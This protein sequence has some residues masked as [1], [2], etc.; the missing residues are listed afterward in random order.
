MSGWNSPT[1]TASVG[2]KPRQETDLPVK[3]EGPRL[4]CGG[5]NLLVVRLLPLRA[6]KSVKLNSTG[7]S[8]TETTSAQFSLTGRDLSPDS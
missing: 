7:V 5:P 6:D 4:K 1:R 2:G 8:E 3:V